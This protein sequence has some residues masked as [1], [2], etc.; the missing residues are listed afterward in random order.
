MHA[1]GQRVDG[2]SRTFFRGL[3]RLQEEAEGA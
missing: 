3:V 2:T 1:G